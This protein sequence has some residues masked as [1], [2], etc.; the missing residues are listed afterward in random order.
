MNVTVYHG[1]TDVIISPQYDAGRDHL[2]F[3]K[4]FYVTD[5]RQQAV[6]WA[7]RMAD[8]RKLP[9]LLN[10]YEL[11]RDSILANHRCKVFAAYD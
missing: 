4:G 9:P 2:D 11:D 7:G 6:D 5:I 8:R 3:G 1:G 10:V